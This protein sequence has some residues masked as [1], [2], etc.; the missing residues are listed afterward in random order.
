MVRL[1]LIVRQKISRQDVSS[2]QNGLIWPLEHGYRRKGETEEKVVALGY[3]LLRSVHAP[4][5][6][7]V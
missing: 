4:R 6:V 1:T 5:T 2:R 7:Q 3:Y